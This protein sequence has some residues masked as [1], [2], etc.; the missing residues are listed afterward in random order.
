MKAKVLG[1]QILRQDLNPHAAKFGVQADPPMADCA[2]RLISQPPQTRAEAKQSFAYLAGRLTDISNVIAE[3]LGSAAIVPIIKTKTKNGLPMEKASRLCMATPQSCFLGDGD[4]YS[5]IFDYVDFG[6]EAN[7]FLLKVGCKHEPSTAELTRLLVRQPGRILQ[8]LGVEKYLNVLRKLYVNMTNLKKDKALWKDMRQAPFLLAYKLRP[9]HPKNKISTQ[10]IDVEID[11]VDE[12]SEEMAREYHLRSADKVILV[13][14]LISYTLF[15]EQLYAAPDEESLEELYAALGVP[16]IST[17]VDEEPRLGPRISDQ[18]EAATLRELILERAQL[19]LYE[20][21]RVTVL[22]DAKWLEKNL[23]VQLVQS[24][25]L[26][27]TLRDRSLSHVEKRSAAINPSVKNKALLCITTKFDVWQVSRE[28]V[29]LLIDRAKTQTVMVFETFLVTNLY[30][31][32]A[33]GYNVDR[34]LRRKAAEARMAE[35]ERQNLQVEEIRRGEEQQPPQHTPKSQHHDSDQEQHDFSPQIMP[36]AFHDSPDRA[37]TAPKQLTQTPGQRKPRGLFSSM[38]RHLG[39]DEQSTPSQDLQNFLGGGHMATAEQGQ[40]ENGLAPPPY[41]SYDPQQARGSSN[42]GV[43]T[44]PTKLQKTLQ[45]AINASRAYGS[46]NLFSRPER[47]QVEDVASYCD[48]RPGQNLSFIATSTPGLQI[49]IS[50]TSTDCN[51]FVSK[52]RSGLDAFASLL[53]NAGSVFPVAAATL[54]VYYDENGNSM[55]FNRQGSLFFNYRFFAQLQLNG[56][57]DPR[58]KAQ[59][60][61]YWWVILCHELAHNLVDSHSSDHS[62][63]TEQFVATYFPAVVERMA[64]MAIGNNDRVENAGPSGR[65]LMPSLGPFA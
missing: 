54:H 56:M 24:L 51:S 17:L 20:Q 62:L 33:R 53:I 44:A 50:N 16:W 10:L 22:H 32:R 47:S 40:P 9:L 49:Y 7:L 60:L 26:R 42:S 41:S 65:E 28:I 23:E 46:S 58:A 8:A 59:A 18:S 38:A 29:S 25:S 35:A 5:D 12:E 64:E 61:V 11:T 63:Y 19:F 15:K 45:S 3:K 55:A 6:P 48:D 13:D 21:P 37:A 31:L 4:D 36:G 1:Y 14:D 57:N 39:F 30:K 34:I 52:N 2:V 43:V 27:R